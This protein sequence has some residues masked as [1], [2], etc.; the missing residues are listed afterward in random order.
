MFASLFDGLPI[1]RTDFHGQLDGGVMTNPLKKDGRPLAESFLI[2]PLGV[3][4]EFTESNGV[5]EEAIIHVRNKQRA[6]FERHRKVRA[7]NDMHNHH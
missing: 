7:E 4:G 2:F 6:Y 5:L 1:D 3:P